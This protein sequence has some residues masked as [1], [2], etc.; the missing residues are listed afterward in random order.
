MEYGDFKALFTG[1]ITSDVEENHLGEWGYCNVLKV[2][3]HGSKTSSGED[4]L[5]EVSPDVAVFCV[6]EDNSYSHP[7]KKV[8][9][10]YRD[11]NIQIYRTDLNGDIKIYADK[12]K[13]YKIST[14]ME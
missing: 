11:R 4:F 7:D 5:D 10:R 6:G 2:P 12:E 13:G 3:H 1:D 8:L 14:Y 9:Q